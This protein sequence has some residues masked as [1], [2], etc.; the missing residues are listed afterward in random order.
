MLKFSY[1]IG[2]AGKISVITDMKRGEKYDDG[3]ETIKI[4]QKYIPE[5]NVMIYINRKE[6]TI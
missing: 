1:L 6:E 3:V 2:Y 5:A 4:V